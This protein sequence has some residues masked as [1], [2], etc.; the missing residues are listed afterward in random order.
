MFG[1]EKTGLNN[2]NVFMADFFNKRNIT[3]V[4]YGLLIFL[5]FVDIFFSQYLNDNIN[6]IK[7]YSL[8]IIG[9][10]IILREIYLKSK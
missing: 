10:I 3:I 2:N 7:I 6:K 9:I 5:L 1:M 4:L 8:I